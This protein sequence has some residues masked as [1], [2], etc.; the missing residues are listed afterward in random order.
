MQPIVIQVDG[1][2]QVTEQRTVR[3]QQGAGSGKTLQKL[4]A[5]IGKPGLYSHNLLL[6]NTLAKSLRQSNCTPPDVL[7]GNVLFV[8]GGIPAKMG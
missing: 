3:R 6:K 8:A 5:R 7:G 4:A 2:G 1:S